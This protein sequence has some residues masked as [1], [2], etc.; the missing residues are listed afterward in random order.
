[1][2]RRTLLA[3]LAAAPFITVRANAA[4]YSTPLTYDTQGRPLADVMLNNTGPFALVIDTAAG[5]IVLNPQT[6]Q[7]LEL[8]PTG[9]AR[10]QGASGITETDLYDLRRV[11]IGGLTHENLR[12]VQTPPDSASAANHEGVLGIG[13]FAG[14]RLEFDFAAN[15]LNVDTSTGR[16]PLANAISVDLRHRTFALAPINIAGIDATALIDTGARATIANARLRTA[17]G[18]TENDPRLHD[19]EPI[20][21]ATAHTTP[22]VAAEVTPVVFAGHDFAAVQLNFAELSVFNALGLNY[23]PAMILGIDVL[24]RAQALVLDYASAQVTLRV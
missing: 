15:R 22:A 3:A 20:G 5:G 2:R 8:N 7:I 16:A 13:V 19:A 9:R 18:F 23:R 24:R 21:G 17:L 4:T 6:I 14:T 12:A 1:M 10:I 11:D